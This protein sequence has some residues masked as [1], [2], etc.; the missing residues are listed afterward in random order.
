MEQA[1]AATQSARE[2]QVHSEQTGKLKEKKNIYANKK[3]NKEEMEQTLNPD[4][5][6]A[7][8]TAWNFGQSFN[9]E[10]TND[11]PICKAIV[12]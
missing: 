9:L 7:I 1:A 12:A 10:I 3:D 4:L 11:L 6:I 5:W 8:A 2:I